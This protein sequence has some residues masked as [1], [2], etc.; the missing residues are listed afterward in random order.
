MHHSARGTEKAILTVREGPFQKEGLAQGHPK[1]EA[2]A[3]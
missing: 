2:V 1:P 3:A